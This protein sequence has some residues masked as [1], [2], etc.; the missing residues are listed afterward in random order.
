MTSLKLLFLLLLFAGGRLFAQE[1]DI[2]LW[3]G[4]EGT[5]KVN[6]QLNF[7]AELENRLND[8]MRRYKTTLLD[9]G[10]TYDFFDFVSGSFT[11]RIGHRQ[12]NNGSF[13]WRERFNT[14]LKFKGEIKKVDLDLRIRWQAGSRNAEE[15]IADYRRAMRY[16]LKAETKIAKKTRGALVGEIYHGLRNGERVVTDWR[17]R[18][19]VKRKL[20][21]GESIKIGYML[22]REAN[23]ANPLLEHIIRI[24]YSFRIN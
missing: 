20:S 1:S 24:S 17:L 22:Q 8:G 5:Y 15:R 16:R 13:G 21:K 3:T 7:S 14:D 23:R 10:A 4:V 12:N 19:E 9:L 18:A 11:Y 2:G 6:K